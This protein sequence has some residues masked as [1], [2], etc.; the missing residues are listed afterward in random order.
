[1]LTPAQEQFVI[2]LHAASELAD[3]P[4]WAQPYWDVFKT[5]WSDPP[6]P[7]SLPLWYQIAFVYSKI[8][9]AEGG[10]SQQDFDM[11]KHTQPNTGTPTD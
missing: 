6:P 7:G 2:N 5:I 9:E 3:P 11:H 10:V 8:L 1:M 4:A